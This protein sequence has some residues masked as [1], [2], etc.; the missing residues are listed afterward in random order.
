MPNDLSISE[1]TAETPGDVDHTVPSA[2]RSDLTVSHQLFE[3]R[4]FAIIKDPLSLKYFRLPAEDFA[5]A[6]LFDGKRSVAEIRAAFVK[7]QPQAALS[8]TSAEM[9]ERIRRFAQEL[10]HGGFLETTVA[11]ARHQQRL[12]LARPTHTTPWG[13]FMKSLFLKIP[14]WDPDALLIRLERRMRWVW[15]WPG[16]I[17]SLLILL[18]GMAVFALNFPRISPS[19]NDFL[20]LPN[21]ALIWALTIVVKIIH[22]FGHGLTCKHYGGEVHEM[23]AM[24]IV[25]SPFLYADVTDSYLFPKKRHR[26]LVAAAGIYI[27]LV[28]AAMATLLWAISQPGPTQ[29]LLF[30]LMLITSVWTVL[31]NANPLMKFDGYY[32]LTDVLDVPNLRAKAQMCVSEMLRRVCF[33]N[34]GGAASVESLLPRRRRGWFVLYS[35]AAQIYLLYITLGIAMLFHHLLKPYGLAWLGDWIGVGAL[36]SMLLVPG[37]SFFTKQLTANRTAA[38]SSRRP[39]VI[40]GVVL[41]L[42]ALL[43]QMPWQVYVERPAM[44]QPVNGEFVR[45]EVPGRLSEIRVKAGQQVKAGD[46]IAVLSSPSLT[47]DVRTAELRLQRVQRELD[48]TIG[49][50]APA[51]F[52]QV[53]SQLAQAKLELD[54][55]QRLTSRLTLRASRAGWVITPDLERLAA[56]SLR[57]GDALC[58][59]VPLD[60]IQIFIPLNERQARYIQAG[61]SVDLRVPAVP[62]KM[63]QG[64][65]IED[66]KTAPARELPPNLVATLGGDLAAQPDAV[67]RLKPLET[68]YGVLV[69]LPNADHSLRPGMTGTV[70]IHGPSQPL[71]RVL[72]MKL[73]DFISLD[74]RL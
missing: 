70:R 10:L 66:R 1:I 37:M 59:I 7:G 56:G 68:T 12:K 16:F 5:L 36:I 73:L 32:I 60:P 28:I 15:S 21:L 71:H 34:S 39:W 58:E 67:G 42:A 74:Y 18:A 31:F 20:A 6:S 61:Q 51:A 9:T 14:L 64:R 26:I 25:F 23:G 19:L 72:W 54:E 3:G 33:G 29:Q 17:I 27:E 35:V 53:Q 52:R 50:E 22:E 69:S 13:L 2:L 11:A 38:R 63:F 43:L 47:A 4:A 8:Q 57:A 65:V 41:L 62:E 55:A 40:L 45:A 49:S 48:L 24:V 44:M 30:N 46:V